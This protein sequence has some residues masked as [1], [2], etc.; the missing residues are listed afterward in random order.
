M[1][2]AAGAKKRR[3]VY[4]FV[5]PP[6]L[7][8]GYGLPPEAESIAYSP[9]QALSQV[10]ARS[11]LCRER[12]RY[13]GV[14]DIDAKSLLANVLYPVMD[15]LLAEVDGRPCGAGPDERNPSADEARKTMRVLGLRTERHACGFSSLAR[16]REP[17]DTLPLPEGLPEEYRRTGR[18]GEHGPDE[19]EPEQGALFDASRR[20][21]ER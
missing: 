5:F 20:H 11:S 14:L 10:V 12:G 18:A 3:S 6:E 21:W 1:K 7:Q 13:R 2:G 19:R 16:D 8:Q 9:K 4:R 15:E 17:S